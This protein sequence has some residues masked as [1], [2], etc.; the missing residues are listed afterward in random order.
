MKR[1]KARK[2]ESYVER[3]YRLLPERDLIS[4]FVKIKDTDLH[5]LADRDVTAAAFELTLQYRLQIEKYIEANPGFLPALRP[6]PP[7]I[8]APPIVKEMLV[9]AS[10]AGVGPM[11]AVAGVIA[12]YVG[13]GLLQRGCTEVMVEN[14]G[15]IYLN[16]RRD[17]TIA[18]FA[19]QSPLSMQVG[20]KIGAADMPLGVCTSSGTV[21]HSLSFGRADA[22][23]VLAASTAL[24]DA[25][26]TRL[27]NEVGTTTSSDA[28]IARA[29]QLGQSINGV[30]GIVVICGDKIGAV[31]KIELVE[32][33]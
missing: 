11:A 25:A 9:A 16:R 18:I 19:G 23:V 10:I 28:G 4:S 32:L 31:G 3:S 20:I 8:L 14:G 2:P 15:D 5:L 1:H 13:K 12:E 30:C 33:H 26:A 17:C 6:L 29:L 7:D 22:V 27:G 24:A 21:G